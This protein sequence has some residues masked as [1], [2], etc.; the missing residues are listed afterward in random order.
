[1]SKNRKKIPKKL[2]VV[3]INDHFFSLYL[4]EHSYRKSCPRLWSL[5]SKEMVFVSLVFF[6]QCLSPLNMFVE[7]KIT[8]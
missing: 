5:N 8:F 6:S 7:W 3:K 1:M 2:Y 4:N